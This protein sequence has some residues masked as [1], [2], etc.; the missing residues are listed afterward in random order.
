MPWGHIREVSFP[1]LGGWERLPRKELNRKEESVQLNTM[2]S[3]PDWVR[4]HAKSPG[5]ETTDLSRT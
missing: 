5:P 3:F 4:A 2:G 1:G